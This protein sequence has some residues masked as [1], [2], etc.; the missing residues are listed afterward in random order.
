MRSH[1]LHTLKN[2]YAYLQFNATKSSTWN[3]SQKSLPHEISFHMYDDVC[4]A[5]RW[6]KKKQQMHFDLIREGCD[7]SNCTETFGYHEKMESE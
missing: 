7:E 2:A 3:I 1:H 4:G 5:S 6:K